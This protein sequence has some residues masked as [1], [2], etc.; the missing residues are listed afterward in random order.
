MLHLPFLPK[1]RCICFLQYGQH[2]FVTVPLKDGGLDYRCMH[3][4]HPAEEAIRSEEEWDVGQRVGEESAFLKSLQ[5]IPNRWHH[6]MP[7][8]S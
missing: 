2:D 6:L 1:Q 3:C 8:R 4:G 5:G 7:W